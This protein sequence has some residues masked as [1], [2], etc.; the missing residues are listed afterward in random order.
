MECSVNTD[1]DDRG[2]QSGSEGTLATQQ[3]VSILIPFRDHI[4]LVQQCLDTLVSSLEPRDHADVEI[5]LINNRSAAG[6]LTELKLPAELRCVHV[7]A[8]CEFNFQHINNL[9]AQVATGE[10]LLLLNNDIVFDTGSQ[11]FLGR[12]RALAALPS[13]GAVGP[14]LWFPDGTIQHAGVVVGMN[15]WA[16]H[17]YRGWTPEQTRGF[18]FSGFDSERAVSAVTAA[19]LMVER[20]KWDL[21]GGM[22]ERFLVCGGDVDLCIRLSRAGFVS[23]YLGSIAMI[24]LESKSRDPAK[25]PA[26]DFVESR[27]VY[28]Q[29][30]ELHC[31]RDPFYPAHL[32]LEHIPEAQAAAAVAWHARVKRRLVSL[33]FRAL[34]QLATEAPEIVLAKAFV[35]VRRKLLGTSVHPQTPHPVL[36]RKALTLPLDEV[37]PHRFRNLKPVSL[38][39][40][41]EE[42]LNI[43]LPAL[44][45]ESMFGGIITIVVLAFCIQAARKG[46]ALRFITIDGPGQPQAVRELIAKYLAPEFARFD[47]S[48]EE[49]HTRGSLDVS[50][51][52]RDF[53]LNTI[54]YSCFQSELL[55]KNRPF[56][57]MVQDFEP[58]FYPW[59]DDYAGA[60]RTYHMNAIPIFNTSLL[61]DFFAR[62][63]FF[64][65]R[66]QISFDPPFLHAGKRQKKAANEKRTLFFYA[67][68]ATPRNLFLTGIMALGRVA[69]AGLLPAAQWEIVSAGE[70]HGPIELASGIEVRSVG[71]MALSAYKDLLTRTDVGLSLMLSPHPSYP[72]LE[73]AASGAVVVTNSYANKD[74]SQ[75]HANVVSCLPI[76]D[77]VAEGLRTAILRAE[78][79]QEQSVPVE[80]E[81]TWP[82]VLA[83]TVAFV[84]R[85]LDSW[86]SKF[87]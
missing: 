50:V 87:A 48:V 10:F 26:S 69:R 35:K 8:D 53:F 65:G 79:E 77:H 67:R 72:P 31:G 47:F 21:V 27:R 45:P 82:E 29:Y 33:W 66:D 74:L 57:Y 78:Q 68:P 37:V 64:M 42:R 43:V 36:P 46:L 55:L 11:G 86:G 84:N 1:N 16:D 60:L 44:T 63:G 40:S 85:H 18:P 54:W 62:E 19:C 83:D 32:P 58:G 9:G 22:D 30:L 7:D 15:G 28:D 6:A 4:S 80:P 76:V 81:L 25:I 23:W 61:R 13:V 75:T 70:W 73:L 14:L 51:H 3:T 5:V 34:H 12:M 20:W 24:H 56:F 71:K 59:G 17:L 52:D 39:Q 49:H 41:A 2:R 38:S